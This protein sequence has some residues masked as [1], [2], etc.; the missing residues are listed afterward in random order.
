MTAEEWRPVPGYDGVYE[1]SNL[2]NVRSWTHRKRGAVMKQAFGTHGYLT[3]CVRGIDGR[4]RR[5]TVHTLVAAAFIGPRPDGT[6]TRH[7]DGNP[8]NNHALNLAYGT[9][10]ENQLDSVRHG[11]HVNASKTYCPQGHPYSGDNL[12]VNPGS[13]RRRCRTCKRERERKPRSVMPTTTNTQK[14]TEDTK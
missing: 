3:V 14:Q 11:S 9:H 12:Y 2:G 7:L 6:E 4:T 8:T 13:G 5:S 10:A 1:V